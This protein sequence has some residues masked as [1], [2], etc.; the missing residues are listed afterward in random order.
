MLDTGCPWGIAGPRAD[1]MEGKDPCLDPGVLSQPG[2]AVP[3]DQGSV[4]GR[5]SGAT[6]G[7]PPQGQDRSFA[8]LWEQWFH[9]GRDGVSN[10]GCSQRTGLSVPS[11]A[12]PAL[13]WSP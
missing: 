6:A 5:H 4:L 3:R 7:S 13:A 8:E 1:C 11:A 2:P 10:P 9:L 12:I